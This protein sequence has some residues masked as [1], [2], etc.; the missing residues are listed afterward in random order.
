MSRL[1]I[2]QSRVLIFNEKS[3]FSSPQSSKQ[4]I[5]FLKI[6]L[7]LRFCQEKLEVLFKDGRRN[8]RSMYFNGAMIQI[9]IEPD[10]S[11]QMSVSP[12]NSRKIE[13]FKSSQLDLLSYHLK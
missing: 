4:P 3:V 5:R 7:T 13:I 10:S 6:S 1:L 12:L 8:P 2:Y 11:H 9:Q